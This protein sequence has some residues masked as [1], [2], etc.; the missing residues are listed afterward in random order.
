MIC[1]QFKN[2]LNAK[3]FV[4]I[5]IENV[6]IVNSKMQITYP[7][8][9]S[10][11]YVTNALVSKLEKHS[12]NLTI[13]LISIKEMHQKLPHY[14]NSLYT[15]DFKSIYNELI[16]SN[17]LNLQSFLNILHEAGNEKMNS[18]FEYDSS[19]NASRTDKD[20]I[21][22]K[23][24]NKSFINSIE[25]DSSDNYLSSLNRT[26]Y[27]EGICIPIMIYN[28]FIGANINYSM[29]NKS[30]YDIACNSETETTQ[31]N[32]LKINNSKSFQ[33]IN[34]S[35]L[36][37]EFKG[38][39]IQVYDMNSTIQS[40][41][42]INSLSKYPVQLKLDK[43]SIQLIQTIKNRTEIPYL[44]II[45]IEPNLDLSLIELKWCNKE[46]NSLVS[47]YF[48]YSSLNEKHIWLA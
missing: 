36:D 27:I 1:F 43:N 18:L 34:S 26:L 17:E 22:K 16:K 20:F 19:A 38:E 4:I 3:Y 21:K 25:L 24:L 14:V 42:M 46:N 48:Q 7:V 45:K 2:R 33:S 13:K 44:S 35:I 6:L 23:Y 29:L 30:A 5:P 11:L 12:T 32:Y 37:S 15:I 31:K 10:L 9:T 8:F 39:I 41:S 28:L 40:L 47:S